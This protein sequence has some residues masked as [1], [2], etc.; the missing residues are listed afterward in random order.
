MV[1]AGY[2]LGYRD[3]TGIV[4]IDTAIDISVRGGEICRGRTCIQSDI[5]GK[6]ISIGILAFEIMKDLRLPAA[7]GR[8]LCFIVEIE[9]WD[10][11]LFG[12]TGEFPGT[13]DILGS[14]AEFVGRFGSH[15][16]NAEDFRPV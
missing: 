7:F 15:R 16:P 5:G 6:C 10:R 12:N 4:G 9:G 2:R 8:I 3:D 1:A 14:S 11:D 13:E